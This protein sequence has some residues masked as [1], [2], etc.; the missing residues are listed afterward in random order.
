M[1]FWFFIAALAFN[2]FAGQ[3]SAMGLPLPPD[4]LLF[5]AA[6]G[7]ALLDPR[8]PAPRWRVVHGLM[9]AFV[10]LATLSA[11]FAGT[12][13]ER[14]SL[15]ALVDR[16]AMPF[17]L[18]A[19]AP[20]FLTARLQRMFFLRAMSLIGAYLAVIAVA[21]FSG[22]SALVYPRYIAVAR[23]SGAIAETFRAGGPFVSG[24][25]N[26][27]ALAI[28]GSLA[29]LLAD[30]DRGGW[31][32]WA[33]TV[34]SMSLAA[35][36]LSM[37]RSVWLGMA[38][39]AFLVALGERRLWRHLPGLAVAG[40]AMLALGAAL[41]PEVVASI[42]GRGAT[43]R[44]LYDRANTNAAAMR[45]IEDQPLFGVGWGRFI[46]HGPD[47][48]RQAQDYPLTSVNIEIHNVVLSRAAELGLLAAGLYV[49]CLLAG[50]G[51]ALLHGRGGDPWHS[52]ALALAVIWLVPAMTSP[53][54]Y[55]FPAFVAFTVLGHLFA[56][57]DDPLDRQERTDATE[58]LRQVVA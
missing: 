17:V 41:L 51:R 3:T 39:A 29:L 40:A 38:L 43:S 6:I 35:S 10:A 11:M 44:S 24:E 22:A 33:A 18:F 28:C 42:A 5:P 8:I 31:R 30:V 37:T 25:A 54:P 13:A 53:N 26:G 16:V 14:D 2:V 32:L 58:G 52:A 27:M 20:V 55:T 12:L 45:A 9:L 19:V 47:W 36:I 50:P 15:Y 7:L 4:R 34:G 48:V 49:L 1:A 23:G 21:Q 57:S 46:Q 56:A